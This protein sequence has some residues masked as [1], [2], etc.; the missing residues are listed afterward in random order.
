M[1]TYNPTK[2][3]KNPIT[4]HMTQSIINGFSMPITLHYLYDTFNMVTSFPLPGT[5]REGNEFFDTLNEIH[6]KA[7]GKD[8]IWI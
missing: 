3:I 2:L 1:Q 6:N 4:L 8:L 7:R 5:E